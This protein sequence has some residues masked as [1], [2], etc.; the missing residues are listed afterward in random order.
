MNRKVQKEKSISSPMDWGGIALLAGGLLLVVFLTF[1]KSPAPARAP[2]P[3]TPALT[4]ATQSIRGTTF[5][6]HPISKKEFGRFVRSTKYKTWRE[7]QGL[8]PTWRNGGQEDSPAT[9]L[10]QPDA[11][12]FCRWLS[13]ETGQRWRLP[14]VDELAPLGNREVSWIWTNHTLKDFDAT[15][16]NA[17]D[18]QTAWH[19]AAPLRH[20][21]LRDMGDPE[22]EPT[23]FIVLLAGT[24]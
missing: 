23:S 14:Q 24:S 18:Y 19:P 7:E 5:S 3:H 12:A 13:Q 1:S 21:R 11:Q 9:W 10:T 17:G 16:G 2:N 22:L 20:R 6:D 4:L 15:L 8:T